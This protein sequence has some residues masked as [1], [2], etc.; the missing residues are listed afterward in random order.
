MK[1]IIGFAGKM[2]SGKGVASHCLRD[3]YGYVYV[4]IAEKLKEICTKLL[5]V[6]SIEEL[7]YLK[8]NDKPID[9]EFSVE[10]CH[11]LSELT[12]I[13]EDFITEKCD[14]KKVTSVR[15]LLQFLGT[16]VLRE[17]DPQWHIKHTIEKIT[18]LIDDGKR[19]VVADVRF[20]NE[21]LAIESIGG[22]VYYV[23][24]NRYNILSVHPSEQ[25]L[26]IED[27][28]SDHIIYN[29]TPNNINIFMYHVMDTL[30]KK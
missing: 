13:P 30:F 11:R 14:H 25:S 26:S 1:S 7:D 2:R 12:E 17:Y 21:K 22:D 16:D 4:E 9:F 23:K 19:V 3:H 24:M 20:P 28:D 10:I 18:K 15:G 5:N 27:F 29:D 6:G 8:N